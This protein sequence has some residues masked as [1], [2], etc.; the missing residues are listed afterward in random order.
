M[1]FGWVLRKRE[2]DRRYLGGLIPA[3]YFQEVLWPEHQE[4]F[5]ILGLSPERGM[6]VFEAFVEIDE[7]NGG[8]IS[9]EE[10]HAW[11]GFSV[12]KFSE[13]VFGILDLDGSG[14]LDFR[15][16]LI[17][18]W[19]W[20]TYDAALV[21][22]LAF[23]IF[24]VE[25][26]GVLEMAECD[27]LL[28][29]VYNVRRADPALMKK[30]DVNGDGKVSL[31]E[32]EQ[33]VEVH[34]YVLQPA[35]DIQ[36]ALRQR[37]CGVRYWETEMQRRRVY[38]SGYDAGEQSSWDSI[39]QIL[40]IK[41]RE[42]VEQE[43]RQRE[44]EAAERRAEME[45]AKQREMQLREEV[46]A[47]RRR[48]AEERRAKLETPAAK[49]ERA[50]IQELE[51]CE[52]AMD[53]ECIAADLSVRLAQRGAFWRAFDAWVDA[54]RQAR[55]IERDQ[56]QNLAAG[57]DAEAKLDDML[58]TADGN[59]AFRA[60]MCLNF[61]YEL[62][63]R[64]V[65]RERC[66]ALCR[67]LA[68]ALVVDH[69]GD[70][71]YEATNLARWA[72][73]WASKASLAAAREQARQALLD[74]TRACETKRVAEDLDAAETE[75]EKL[76]ESTRLQKV[77]E[78][79]GPDSKWERLWDGVHGAPY[80]L[81]WQ[82][83]ESRW[84][85]PHVCHICDAA[86]DVDDVRCFRCNTDRSAYNMDLYWNAHGGKPPEPPDDAH[87]SDSDDDGETAAVDARLT[88]ASSSS[89]Q[90][91]HQHHGAAAPKKTMPARSKRPSSAVVVQY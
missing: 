9:I 63:D 76:F 65:A 47:R 34:N 23:S 10:F 42:R 51:R 56:R 32:L 15:E 74:E 58:N 36:R 81:Q 41:H 59:A 54:A 49:A 85:H 84:E 13:R 5:E 11:L 53:E 44:L 19:N 3:K 86:I 6:E 20:S 60:E 78:R 37:I 29:T 66:K 7:D 55:E 24:D 79:G 31:E 75:Q 77:G 87:V 43:E 70:G 50:A 80:W 16:F 69:F 52:A 61:A 4:V 40:E 1:M 27:A 12:T 45:A 18:V 33:V 2:G 25:K 28:R 71:S 64:L 38:F 83:N 57:S 39:K 82:T 72:M 46:A 26:Q 67:K 90:R 48:R 62:H 8:E 68:K 73:R 89:D 35:F 21:T 91:Q 17:G 88:A 22:K 14:F 30:M